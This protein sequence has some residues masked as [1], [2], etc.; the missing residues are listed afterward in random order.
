MP[1][2]RNCTTFWCKQNDIVF[3]DGLSDSQFAAEWQV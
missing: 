1:E 3:L 2:T